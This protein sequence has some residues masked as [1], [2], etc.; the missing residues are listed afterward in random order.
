MISQANIGH[1][2]T[3]VFSLRKNDPLHIAY[4]MV[5]F[6]AQLRGGGIAAEAIRVNNS[7][8]FLLVARYGNEAGT[9]A[10]G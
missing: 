5:R 1:A 10:K 4:L 3:E 8:T 2:P 7:P 9:A 6:M